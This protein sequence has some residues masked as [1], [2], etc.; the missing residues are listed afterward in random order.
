MK[1]RIFVTDNE[2]VTKFTISL[3]SNEDIVLEADGGP[4][5]YISSESGVIFLMKIDENVPLLKDEK[6]YP[7]TD[8]A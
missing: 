6:G 4:I 2:K 5:L 3:D 7:I 8:Y 1:E